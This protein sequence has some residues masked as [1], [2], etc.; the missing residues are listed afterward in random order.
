MDERKNIPNSEKNGAIASLKDETTGI[1]YQIPVGESSVGREDKTDEV[2]V[3]ITFQTTDR[4]MSH[5]HAFLLL[6]RN[7][8]GEY[9][10]YIQ[11]TRSRKNR[12]EVNNIPISHTYY[13]QVYNQD[14]ICMGRTN[15]TVFLN[16]VHKG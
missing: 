13:S 16:P 10:L 12:S 7:I 8:I 4:Y 6:K 11:D 2:E 9:A 5:K 3:N 15:F 14:V 1:V